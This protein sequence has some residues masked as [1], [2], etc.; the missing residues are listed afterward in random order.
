MG[1]SLFPVQLLLKLEYWV[2]P[3][4]TI[5]TLV[6]PSSIRSLYK[7]FKFPTRAEQVPQFW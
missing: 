4:A 5:L 3:M 1:I 2:L 6:I 7:L